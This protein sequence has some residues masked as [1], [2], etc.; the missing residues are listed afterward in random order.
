MDIFDPAFLPDLVER[1][2]Y[3]GIFLLTTIESTFVPIP[4]EVTVIPAGILAAK[5]VMN[6]WLVIATSTLGVIAGSAINY[7]LGF[8]YGRKLILRYGKYVF[9]T[10]AFLEKTEKFF[11]KYGKLAVFLGRV[12]P[13]VKHY[14]AFA[15]GIAKMSIKPFLIYSALGGLVWMWLLVH[16]GYMAEINA[17]KGTSHFSSLEIIS[18]AIVGVTLVALFVKQKM[19][20]H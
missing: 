11:A 10:P 1:M 16:I 12:L 7:W 19:M 5:G 14:I 3:V 2:G 18:V 13:G 20:K 8:H 17:E 6:Y 4:A 9:M 15:A